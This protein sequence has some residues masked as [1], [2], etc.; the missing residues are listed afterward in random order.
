MTINSLFLWA[1]LGILPFVAPIAGGP[2][3][4]CP[5]CDCCGCC[6]TGTCKCTTCTCECC[7]DECPTGGLKAEQKDCCGSGCCS[8]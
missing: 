4:G 3:A 5:E 6:E 2:M 7:V 8:N 1:T